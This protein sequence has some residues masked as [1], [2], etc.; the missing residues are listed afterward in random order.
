LA[1][2]NHLPTH[3]CIGNPQNPIEKVKI[4][5][6]L[7]GSSFYLSDS[8][9]GVAQKKLLD[10]ARSSDQQYCSSSQTAMLVEIIG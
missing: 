9:L 1:Q 7:A 3:L 4:T 5:T 6:V 8:L 10:F 2:N